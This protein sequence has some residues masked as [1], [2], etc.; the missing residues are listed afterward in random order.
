MKKDNESIIKRAGTVPVYD[1]KIILIDSLKHKN[2]LVLPKG[3]IKRNETW[4]NAANRETMEESGA[5]GNL[6]TECLIYDNDVVYYLLEVKEFTGSSERK[7][8][9]MSMEE[10][11]NDPRIKKKIQR[12]IKELNKFLD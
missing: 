3:K 9:L 2:R 1:K 10:V 11:I 4:E 8:Y 12:I 6:K 5:V 7:R